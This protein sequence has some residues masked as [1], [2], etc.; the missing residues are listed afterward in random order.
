[1]RFEWDESKNR[2]NMR[3]HGVD[4]RDAAYAFADPYALNIPDDEHSEAEE[5]WVLLG[6]DA[7]QRLLLVVHTDRSQNTIRLISARAAT[8]QERAAY[9]ARLQR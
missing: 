4:F 6:M 9:Q 3:K 8:R 2:A 7:S 5:R 1:M